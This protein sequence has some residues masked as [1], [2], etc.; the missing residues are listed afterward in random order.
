[1]RLRGVIL[2]AFAIFGIVA[3]YERFLATLPP[4]AASTVEAPPAL[5][6]FSVVLTLSFDAARDEF[7]LPDDPALVVSVG[8]HDLFR[9]EDCV[10]AV[11]SLKAEDVSGIA[12]GKNAFFIRAIPAEADLSRHCAV[13]VQILRDDIL[14]AENT[15]WSQPGEVVAGEIVVEV[16]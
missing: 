3:A 6:K 10:T 9:R 15:L 14:L 2:L 4:S 16:Q 1:M 11:E 12:V 7:A 13:K 5:G 8:G